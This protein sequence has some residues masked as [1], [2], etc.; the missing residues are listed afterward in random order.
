MIETN[1]R[2]KTPGQRQDDMD[3]AREHYET[4]ADRRPKQRWDE[5]LKQWVKNVKEG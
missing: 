3:W 1:I 4:R 5:K 2:N